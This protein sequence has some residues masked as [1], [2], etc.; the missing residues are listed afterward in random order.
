MLRQGPTA[1]VDCQDGRSDEGRRAADAR[2]ATAPR[3]CGAEL[4]DK[5]PGAPSARRHFL[6]VT[7]LREVLGRG[8]GA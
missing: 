2:A 3:E 1:E 6:R 5:S 4:H 8:P 7:G